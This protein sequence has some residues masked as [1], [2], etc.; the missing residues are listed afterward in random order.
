MVWSCLENSDSCIR[1][2]EQ[3][4]SCL[5]NGKMI[6]IYIYIYILLEGVKNMPIND[7]PKNMS[8]DQGYLNRDPT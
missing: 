4:D 7:V 3:V 6:N 5:G 8:Y 2:K 1:E